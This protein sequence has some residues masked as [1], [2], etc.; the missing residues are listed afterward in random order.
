MMMPSGLFWAWGELPAPGCASVS[1]AHCLASA[2][3]RSAFVSQEHPTLLLFGRV[4]GVASWLQRYV[5]YPKVSQRCS[6]R[7]M[8]PWNLP[9][10]QFHLSV[11]HI[12]PRLTC[13]LRPGK[14]DQPS[15]ETSPTMNR[16][17]ENAL[18]NVRVPAE[19]GSASQ[20]VREAAPSASTAKQRN[21]AP[22]RGP[23]LRLPV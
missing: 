6:A 22:G 3:P 5:S 12:A 13:R 16:R 1:S 9:K 21:H 17:Q 11:L 18:H 10:K 20:V 14:V 4:P 23:A 8:G 19:T 7:S 2:L 15:N